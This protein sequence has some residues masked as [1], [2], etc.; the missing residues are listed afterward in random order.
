[1][2]VSGV[3]VPAELS[4]PLATLA[5]LGRRVLAERD[6][7]AP[8]RA[9]VAE[10]LDQLVR[11]AQAGTRRDAMSAPGHVSP[12]VADIE[13][14]SVVL[15]A[16]WVTVPVAAGLLTCS[17]RHVRRLVGTE[18]EGRKH[19]KSWMISRSSINAYNA[20]RSR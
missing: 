16:S 12:T 2:I 14:A 19:G 3:L 9:D 10:L 20:S 17:E 8:L 4:G 5:Q 7:A 1:M 11:V 18:L 6:G 15:P 13:A